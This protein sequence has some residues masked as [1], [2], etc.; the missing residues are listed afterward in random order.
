MARLLVS[1]RSPEEA[2]AAFEGGAEIIDV[3]EPSRGPLGRA[4]TTVWKA[5]RTMVPLTIPVSVALGEWHE[6]VGER[7]SPDLSGLSFWKMG[8]ANSAEAWASNWREIQRKWQ[9]GP[10][11]IAV[12]YADRER[13][14][15]PD[16]EHVLDEAIDSGECVGILIDTWDKTYPNPI[17]LTW[18][19]WFDRARDSGLTTALAGRLD[20]TMIAQLAPLHPDIIAVRGAACV[21]GNRRGE[22]DAGRVAALA[23][24]AHAV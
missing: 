5:V 23:R 4:D 20:L 21:G 7:N 24:A 2:L 12:A 16:P 18:K 22:I 11:W 1:V 13:A 8:L 3:K 17:G 9:T 6:W 10:G 19:P 14:R 15:S